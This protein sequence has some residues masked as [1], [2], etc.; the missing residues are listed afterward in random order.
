MAAVVVPEPT[1]I[2]Y[3]MK[4]TH[5]GQSSD[6]C[7]ECSLRSLLVEP[8]VMMDQSKVDG[9]AKT[10]EIRSAQSKL[11]TFISK[12][13]PR[14]ICMMMRVRIALNRPTLARE[15]NHTKDPMK[16]INRTYHRL[17][18]IERIEYC[19]GCKKYCSSM[20]GRVECE[21]GT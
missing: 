3:C 1:T 6:T 21:H 7:L 2:T 12:G 10:K 13:T 18:S 8:P 16:W 20:L 17:S 19:E 14:S 4:H 5:T 9:D 11:D 15:F